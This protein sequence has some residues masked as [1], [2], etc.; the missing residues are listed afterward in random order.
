MKQHIK[1]IT[2][3]FSMQPA[4]YIVTEKEPTR[5]KH[6]HL[7]R[8]EVINEQTSPN[9]MT[10]FYVGFDWDENIMFKYI[11]ATVNV[12]YYYTDDDAEPTR[13]TTA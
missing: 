1:S 4:C 12:T 9:D 8:I 11:A 2:E 6:F 7:K 10:T 13:T 5:N 3:A